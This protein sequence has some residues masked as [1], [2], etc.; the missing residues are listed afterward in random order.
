MLVL[1]VVAVL[2]V[3]AGVLGIAAATGEDTGQQAVAPEAGK[4]VGT[5]VLPSTVAPPHVEW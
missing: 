5:P 2:V 1:A 4:T 3:A